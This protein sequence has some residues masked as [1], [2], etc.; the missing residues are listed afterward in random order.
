[1][2]AVKVINIEAGESLQD[3]LVEVNIL[4]ECNHPNI[5]AYY[6]CYMTSDQKGKP[7]LWVRA[8]RYLLRE[9]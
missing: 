1:M 2:A 4:R 6:G 8:W 3:V 9:G 7:Q 5:V